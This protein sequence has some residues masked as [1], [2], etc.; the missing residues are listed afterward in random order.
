MMFRYKND[1]FFRK[2][3]FFF[4]FYWLDGAYT[5]FFKLIVSKRRIIVSSLDELSFWEWG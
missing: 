3:R 2:G 5:F 4:K 1:I